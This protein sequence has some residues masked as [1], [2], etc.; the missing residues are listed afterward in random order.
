MKTI[1]I[2]TLSFVLTSCFSEKKDQALTSKSKAESM[3]IKDTPCDETLSEKVK[4]TNEG[5][6]ILSDDSEG[7]KLEE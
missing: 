1:I 6:S 5:L 3:K 4:I 7:C 2:L